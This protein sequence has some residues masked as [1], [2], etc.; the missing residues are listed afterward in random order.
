MSDTATFET[1]AD[2]RRLDQPGLEALF[3]TEAPP[4]EPSGLFRG[5][6]LGPVDS[7]AARSLASRLLI[8]PAFRLLPFSVDFSACCW[9]MGLPAVR[10]G[11]FRAERGPSRWRETEVLQLHYEASRLPG[12]VRRL[13]YDEVK[14]L[15]DNLCLGLGGV[16]A[17]KGEGEIFFFALERMK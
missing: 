17:E 1:T 15:S 7:P 8:L 10:A 6:Y 16:N 5:T 9:V 12:P 14:P 2:L 4:V 11:R 3:A 13:L